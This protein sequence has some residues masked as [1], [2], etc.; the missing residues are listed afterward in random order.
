MPPVAFLLIAQILTSSELPETLGTLEGR[1]LD[2]RD[3]PVG[4][5][6]VMVFGTRRG[7]QTDEKGRFI[8]TLVPPGRHVVRILYTGIAPLTDTLD[9]VPGRNGVITFRM[10]ASTV[11]EKAEVFIPGPRRVVSRGDLVAEIVPIRSPIK[12]YETPSFRVRIWNRS[13]RPIVLVT[14]NDASQGGGSPRGTFTI[15]A[16]FDAFDRPE[17]PPLA[18]CGNGNFSVHS[19]DFIEV[20]PGEYF[21]PFDRDEVTPNFRGAVP[22]RPGHYGV[23]FRY[24]TSESDVY[25]WTRR[26]ATP[27]LLELLSRVPVVDLEAKATFK[28][29]Y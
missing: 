12:I 8:L 9:V 19:R 10:G 27:E 6:N 17:K 1:V 26:D 21:E 11:A 4:F 14:C 7:A 22:T 28:V 5:A 13:A 15:A 18:I 16:P 3:R 23:T 24:S 29:D 25:Y 2:A 20:Q